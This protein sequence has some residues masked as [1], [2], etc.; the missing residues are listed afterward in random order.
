MGQPSASA[1]R[2]SEINLFKI[3]GIKE[4]ELSFTDVNINNE[5]KKMAKAKP[6]GFP[7][8]P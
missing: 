7:F 6:E 1:L 3:A 4:E 5:L 8:R 2:E